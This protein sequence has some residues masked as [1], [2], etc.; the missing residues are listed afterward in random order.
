MRL[1]VDRQ[2]TYYIQFTEVMP[3]LFLLN[4]CNGEGYYFRY[5]DGKTP[6]IKF[7]IPDLG[8]YE[9][10]VPF[11]VV[12][13]VGIE[14]PDNLPVLP[15]AERSRIKEVTVVDNADIASPARIFTGSGKIEV[16]ENF[17]N[18]IEPIQKFLLWHEKGHLFYTSE[19]KCDLFALVN[20]FRAGYNQSTAYFTLRNILRRTP[21]NIDRTKKILQA[22]DKINGL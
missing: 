14:I 7:N 10:N 5:L 20:F 3:K 8:C 21:E 9:G 22:I 15:P 16:N 6:R 11:E 13:I 18:Y 12:K 4:K 2:A 1:N 19:D 17:R